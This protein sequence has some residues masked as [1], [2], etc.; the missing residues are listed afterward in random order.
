[1][2]EDHRLNREPYILPIAQSSP[3]PHII[4]FT[5]FAVFYLTTSERS[6]HSRITR[7]FDALD[8]SRAGL[9]SSGGASMKRWLFFLA[10]LG[11]LLGGVG[12]ARAGSIT[13]DESGNGIGTVGRG[14]LAP[15]P[16]PGGLP[17][18]LIYNLPFAGLQ[19]DVLIKD[20]SLTGLLG[21]VV[22]FNGNGTLIFYSDTPPIDSIPGDTPSPPGALYPNQAIVAE[23][24]PEGNNAVIYTPT[25]NQPGFDVSNP[26][27]T[28]VSDGTV[29]EPASLTLLGIG[30][31]GIAGY[32]LRKRKVVRL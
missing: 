7:F 10:A 30:I 22:R 3:S 23:I 15:D 11:L 8:V 18:V 28:F 29:P 14:F 2:A 32:G 25:A 20:G 16:G 13:V 24:G 9:F 4:Y 17:A 27:Y 6:I 19:G 31:A 1:V 21:D 26:T 5:L 12:Q